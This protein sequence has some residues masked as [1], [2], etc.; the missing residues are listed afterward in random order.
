ML[1]GQAGVVVK[2]KG[3]RNG[4]PSCSIGGVALS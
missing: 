2:P 4:K 1:E 3:A